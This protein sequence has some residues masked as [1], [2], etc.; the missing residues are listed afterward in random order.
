ML[1][2]VI[3][4]KQ[5]LK[6]P[7]P[8]PMGLAGRPRDPEAERPEPRLSAIV[9]R[10]RQRHVSRQ[11]S[12]S[13]PQASHAHPRGFTAPLTRHACSVSVLSP[14]PV[15]RV[16]VSRSAPLRLRATS[17]ASS[18]ARP[19]RTG[20]TVRSHGPRARRTDLRYAGTAERHGGV[21]AIT[22]HGPRFGLRC[23]VKDL[24]AAVVSWTVISYEPHTSRGL[25]SYSRGRRTHKDKTIK[26][27]A[28][29]DTARLT[30]NSQSTA[31][32]VHKLR[33]LHWYLGAEDTHHPNQP[34]S[35]G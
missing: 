24:L 11:S 31:N 13:H 8:H 20:G 30:G 22:E 35:R 23:G 2:S 26:R 12:Q 18:S 4:H 15:K 14:C 1:K 32:L 33:I 25:R 17:P 21:G 9:P 19:T 29:P 28:S 16:Q 5:G 3:R 34:A 7:S 27:R 6:S 10:A